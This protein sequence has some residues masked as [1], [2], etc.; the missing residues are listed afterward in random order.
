MRENILIKTNH[1]MKQSFLPNCQGGK[2]YI[3][4][5]EILVNKDL[6]SK[7]IKFIHDD[8]LP[9]ETSIGVN[10]HDKDEEYYYFIS[11]KGIMTSDDEKYEFHVR[12]ITAVFPGGSHGLENKFHDDLRI[13]VICIY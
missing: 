9:P 5:T 7:K 3:D 8:I 12:D 13:L 11:G 10:R 6:K 4:W 2:G 1:N